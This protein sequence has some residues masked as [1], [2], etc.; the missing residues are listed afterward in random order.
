MKLTRFLQALPEQLI[1]KRIANGW[2]QKRLAEKL[3]V[4]EQMVQRWEKSRYRKITF[5]RLLAIA[6]VLEQEDEE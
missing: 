3:G 6:A 1:E 2:T 5:S 4:S